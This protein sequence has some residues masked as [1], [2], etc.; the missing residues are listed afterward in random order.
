MEEARRFLRY[1][2]PGLAFLIEVSIYLWISDYFLCGNQRL[3]SNSIGKYINNT[4]FPW[5]I[6]VTSGGVG[7][8][9]SVIY[10]T[11]YWVYLPPYCKMN[12]GIN[13]ELTR[14]FKLLSRVDHREALR[15]AVDNRWIEIQQRNG[16]RADIRCFNRSDAWVIVTE[17][18]HEHLKIFPKIEGANPRTDSLTDIMHGLGAAYIG[19]ILSF[20]ILFIYN[21]YLVKEPFSLSRSIPFLLSI[22]M[23]TLHNI[24]FSRTISHFQRIVDII[25]LDILRDNHYKSGEPIVVTSPALPHHRETG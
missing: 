21:V 7:F 6:F 20:F 24:N 8:I 1:V 16:P 17:F 2:F 19:S 25:F 15:V 4:A 13:R 5:S 22:L 14:R 18:W 3:F 11:F 9:L 23:A 12:K 10:H